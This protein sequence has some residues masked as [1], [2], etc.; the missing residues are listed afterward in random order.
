MFRRFYQRERHFLRGNMQKY[1]KWARGAQKCWFSPYPLWLLC[2]CLLHASKI[3][4]NYSTISGKIEEQPIVVR[5]R[6]QLVAFVVISS[7]SSSTSSAYAGNSSNS[8]LL[9]LRTF[10]VSSSYFIYI[11]RDPNSQSLF[12]RASEPSR[13]E[14]GHESVCVS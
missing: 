7:S 12:Q 2:I 14:R 10:D 6:S 4:S 1:E 9:V 3:L 5:F 13:N 11:L 8:L